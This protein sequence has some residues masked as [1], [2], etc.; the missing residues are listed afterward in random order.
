M[1]EMKPEKITR[2]GQPIDLVLSVDLVRD[3]I[4]VRPSVVLDRNRNQS[5]V[6]GQTNP[7]TPESKIGQE[8]EASFLVRSGADRVPK[9]WGFT[10]TLLEIAPAPDSFSDSGQGSLVIGYPREGFQETSVRLHY[11]VCPA[12]HHGLGLRFPLDEDAVCYLVD[13]SL[14]GMLLSMEG[15]GPWVKGQEVSLIL[16][17][18]EESLPLTAEVIRTFEE[19]SPKLLFAGFR[20][21]DLEPAAG[22]LIQEEVNRIMRDELK[23]R[24]R[25]RERTPF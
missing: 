10:T 6:V 23:S 3:R 7:P 4:D 8:I 12:Q 13:I 2:P 18:R 15:G 24:S 21:L 14:G 1:D 11:R 5:L 22:R 19:E 16:D 20:F 17:L 25:L 9:R